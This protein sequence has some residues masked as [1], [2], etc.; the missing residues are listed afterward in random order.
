MGLAFKADIDDLRSSPALDI[1]VKLSKELDC[2]LLA[3]EP[4]IEV[5]PKELED[6]PVKLQVCW[7]HLSRLTFWCCWWTTSPSSAFPL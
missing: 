1:T 3:V 4:N 7:M 6:S 5:L 2:T